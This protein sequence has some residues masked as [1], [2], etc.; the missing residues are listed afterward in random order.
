MLILHAKKNKR[1]VILSMTNEEYWG[2]V[3]TLHKSPFLRCRDKVHQATWLGKNKQTKN[4]VRRKMLQENILF[5][6]NY[7]SKHPCDVQL[8]KVLWTYPL[9]D[10]QRS[11]PPGIDRDVNG[12]SYRQLGIACALDDFYRRSYRFIL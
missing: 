7:P 11:V 1:K 4:K 9:K 2:R 12:S 8:F 6:T 3:L 5:K 10:V